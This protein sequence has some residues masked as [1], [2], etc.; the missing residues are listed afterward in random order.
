MYCSKCGTEAPANSRFCPNCGS[1]LTQ[2]YE[3]SVEP[4]QTAPPRKSSL[5]G[6]IVLVGLVAFC[7]LCLGGAVAGYWFIPDLVEGWNPSIP[8]PFVSGDEPEP[9]NVP[10]ASDDQI[11][12]MIGAA[13][14]EV[15]CSSGAKV[16]VPA[17]VLPT[18]TSVNLARLNTAYELPPEYLASAV[19][20]AYDISVDTNQTLSQAIEI[21]LPLELQEGI[22]P[23]LYT[24]FRLDDGQ[25]WDLG[26]YVEGATIHAFTTQTSILQPAIGY[27]VYRSVGFDNYGPYYATV[28][29]WSWIPANSRTPAPPPGGSCTAN[30]PT[31][32]GGGVGFSPSHHLS[33]PLGSYTFC[34][35]W[36]DG[37]DRD[38][39]QY[40]DYYHT[41]F[42]ANDR[43][44][45]T[46]DIPT[47]LDLVPHYDIR[48]TDGLPGPCGI[49]P[50]TTSGAAASTSSTPLPV[51][52]A[53]EVTIRLSWSTSDDLDLHVLEPSGEE[54]YF[55]HPY[56]GAGGELDVDANA[57][58]SSALAEPIE[59][60]YWPTGTP[61]D[62]TYT[63]RVHYWGDCDEYGPVTFRLRIMVGGQVV[64]DETSAFS[65]E[66]DEYEVTFTR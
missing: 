20:S 42:P 61:P 46:A 5:C 39:D 28:M 63:V 58:C 36:T 13:G 16:V 53:G 30:P 48:T 38:D 15:V 21:I 40:F 31:S 18:E 29:A 51:P 1:S 26:G 66:E 7:F 19:G 11:T 57:A 41:I 47:D 43:I 6:P 37:E 35:Q 23:A 22:D 52:S 45:I 33:L 24:V 49:A 60:V 8:V 55:Y 3:P 2:T 10:V 44:G 56:S 65:A 4:L 32:P 54:I 50:L 27:T 62:G 12:A 14:G 25:W 34:V 9:V 59:N 64:L 17:G